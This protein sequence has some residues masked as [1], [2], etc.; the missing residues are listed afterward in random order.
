M[1]SHARSQL[2]QITGTNIAAARERLGLTQREVAEQVNAAIPGAKLSPADVSRWERHLVE[3]G[4][5]YRFALAEILF[6][7]E[8]AAMYAEGAVAA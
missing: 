8:L 1:T 6:D 7:G 4:P 3:P 5:K 2:A